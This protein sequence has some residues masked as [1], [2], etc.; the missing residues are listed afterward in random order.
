MGVERIID[1]LA[2]LVAFD[3]TSRNSNLPLIAWVEDHLRPLGFALERIP[4]ATGAKAN[5]LATIG[6]TDV[7]GIVLSAHT[8]TVPVDGQDWTHD[9]FRLRRDGDRL[10]ARGACDMKGFVAAC[11]AAAE[12][13]AREPLARP[14]HLALT[15]D[16]EV[17]CIGAKSLVAVLAAWPVRPQFCFVGEPTSMGLVTA[18]KAKRSV[19]ATVR[20]FTC[21]SALATQG[22]NAVEYAAR[23]VTE[24]RRMRDRLERDGPRDPLYDVPFSTAHVGLIRGGAALNIVPDACEMLFEFRTIAGDDPDALIAEVVGY[25]RDRLEP[26]MRAV[27]PVAGFAFDVFAGFPGLDTEPDSEIVALARRLTGQT[28][29]SKVAYGTEAG[30]FSAVAGIPSLVIGPGSIEQAH[31]ADEWIAVDQLARCAEFL[32]RLIETCR[33]P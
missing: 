24:I 32:D 22:V 18:H 31:K 33:R 6:P 15:H 27:H 3:T 16:E 29:H 28:T 13:I 19:R 11:L 14:I 1:I 20:G 9:P 23:L 10:L 12:T 21:H 8:D 2:T 7:P 25:A 17:G 4:D 30:L 5:L 26:E